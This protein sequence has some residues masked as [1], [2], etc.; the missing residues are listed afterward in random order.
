VV[1]DRMETCHTASSCTVSVVG[2]V[3][4]LLFAF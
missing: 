4:R 3:L 1:V 2:F